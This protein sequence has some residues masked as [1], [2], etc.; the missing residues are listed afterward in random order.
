MRLPNVWIR[1]DPIGNAWR[2]A[3]QASSSVDEDVTDP[4]EMSV[5]RMSLRAQSLHTVSYAETGG[6]DD[7]ANSY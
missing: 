3:L 1:E 4:S 7:H 2:S 5:L 6:S